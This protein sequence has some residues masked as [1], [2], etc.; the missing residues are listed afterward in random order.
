MYDKTALKFNEILK[1]GK[2]Y[3]FKNGKVN[4]ANK[5]YSL[6]NNDFNLIFFD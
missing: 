6:L 2:T 4:I 1:Q 3:I 5:K